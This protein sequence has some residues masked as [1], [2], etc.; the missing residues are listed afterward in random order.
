MLGTRRR[1][2]DDRRARMP[3]NSLRGGEVGAEKK[4]AI[5][6]MK[7]SNSSKW[8]YMHSIADILKYTQLVGLKINFRR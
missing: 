1:S 3:R 7:G 4:G 6:K 2:Q 8:M 5:K